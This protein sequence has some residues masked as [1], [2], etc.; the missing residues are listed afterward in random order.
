M[1]KDIV[2]LLCRPGSPIILVYLSL[3]LIP[4]SKLN[5]FS[6]GTKYMGWENFVIFDRNR[7]LSRKQYK[8]GPLLLW[9]INRQLYML[10]IEWWHFQWPWRT[11]NSVFKVM[12][13]LK[14]NIS[15]RRILGTLYYRTLI[16]KH[17][18]SIE[19]VPLSA[20]L[21]GW[22]LTEISRLWY[23]STLNISETTRDRVIVAVEHQ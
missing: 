13:F 4:I 16:G 10:S 12:A 20:T 22:P 17:T 23:F 3:A 14:S 2:K 7:C 15:K 5:P 9:N 8:I 1:A 6:G 11:P 18:Q 19:V 21:I